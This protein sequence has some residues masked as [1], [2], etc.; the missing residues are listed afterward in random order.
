VY[1][2]ETRA[3]SRIGITAAKIAPAL[4]SSSIT[5][6]PEPSSAR[7][8]HRRTTGSGPPASGTSRNGAENTK[9]P[10]SSVGPIPILRETGVAATDPTSPP[11]APAP[12]TRPSV[13]AETP[14]VRVA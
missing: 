2:P 10:T 6:N 8:R 14:S 7:N 13:P 11:T 5:P 4:M 9:H 1:A 3:R 12:R